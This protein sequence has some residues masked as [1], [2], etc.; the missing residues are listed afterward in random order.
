MTYMWYILVL[1]NYIMVMKYV[2][3]SPVWKHAHIHI[4]V[5]IHR[6]WKEHPHENYWFLFHIDCRKLE[7]PVFFNIIDNIIC[8]WRGDY[9]L[10][11]YNGTQEISGPATFNLVLNLVVSERQEYIWLLNKLPANLYLLFKTYLNW[12]LMIE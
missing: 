11:Y 5:Y 7:K 10:L 9:W 1:V 8:S 12:H 6:T 4:H 2:V 3:T